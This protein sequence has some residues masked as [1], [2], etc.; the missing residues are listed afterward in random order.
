MIISPKYPPGYINFIDLCSVANISVIM[1]NE[2]L[3]GYYIHGRSPS[4]SADVSFEKLRLNL[5]AECQ[6]NS[7]IRGIHPSMPDS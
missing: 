3:N 2:D 4:G 5:Q 7:T 1:F 6:G